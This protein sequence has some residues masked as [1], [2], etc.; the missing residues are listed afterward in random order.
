MTPRDS[1]W[2]VGP[3]APRL[4]ANEVQLWSADLQPDPARLQELAP[5]LS[6]AEN[7][8]AARFRFDRD[9]HQYTIARGLLRRLLGV[10][11]DA[12]PEQIPLGES[13]HGRPFLVDGAPSA[14]FD[15]NL[16]HSG[17][18]VLFAFSADARVGV[19]VEW[20]RPLPDM[21]DLVALNFSEREQATWR[22][23]PEPLRER[24]FYD[25][26]TRKEAFVKAIGEGLSRPLGS[27]D[28]RFTADEP[29]EF[30]RI[31]GD[32]PAGWSL[33]DLDA[34]PDYAAAIAVDSPRVNLR[35]WAVPNAELPP[36]R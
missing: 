20:I 19:D 25:C 1:L 29:P 6:G 18:R 13:S 17:T 21:A 15:F 36:S 11:C 34:G 28:V 23:L 2:P 30:E 9:A 3:L 33:R 27:F 12:A 24:A 8:R 35:C 32:D 7:E 31:E 16:S 26:W 22:A 14:D 10:Y 5:L 4:A